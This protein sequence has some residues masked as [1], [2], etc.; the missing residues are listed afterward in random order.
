MNNI[1]KKKVN[2]TDIINLN[3][4]CSKINSN[5][6]AEFFFKKN[7]SQFSILAK[8]FEDNI[9]Y[10]SSS[11]T[12]A[13]CIVLNE[14][15][16]PQTLHIVFQ[17]TDSKQDWKQNLEFKTVSIIQDG[18]N[19]LRAH[20]GFLEQFFSLKKYIEKEIYDFNQ[21]YHNHILNIVLSGHS[22]GGAVASICGIYLFRPQISMKIITIGSPKAFCKHLMKWYDEHLSSNT[23]RVVNHQDSIPHLPPTGPIYH[24]EQPKECILIYLKENCLRNVEQRRSFL[25]LMK[26]VFTLFKEHFIETYAER[27]QKFKIL[28]NVII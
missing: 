1:N 28:Q 4:A 6:D 15:D 7:G 5:E 3:H 16:N 21:N 13:E 8:K 14:K 9:R 23:F 2:L 25:E 11:K 12:D 18:P 22:L 17:G 24:Y 10:Y 26:N 19:H 20:K 27:V